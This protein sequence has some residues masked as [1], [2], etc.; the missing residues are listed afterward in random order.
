[1]ICGTVIR[2]LRVHMC[3]YSHARMLP[4]NHYRSSGQGSDH[5]NVTRVSRAAFVLKRLRQRTRVY[6][7]ACSVCVRLRVLC[8]CELQAAWHMRTD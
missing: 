1:M 8:V 7:R 4:V 2:W 6:V 3:A 5:F